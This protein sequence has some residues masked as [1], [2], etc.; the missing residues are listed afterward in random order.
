MEGP[1]LARGVGV[2]RLKRSACSEILES[3]CGERE[4]ARTSIETTLS[5]LTNS[6]RGSFLTAARSASEK[7]AENPLSAERYESSRSPRLSCTMSFSP[8]STSSTES[9][10]TTMYCPGILPSLSARSSRASAEAKAKK[11]SAAHTGRRKSR[12][13]RLRIFMQSSYIASREAQAPA[14][15]TWEQVENRSLD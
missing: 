2:T 13:R 3:S 7:R 6:T 5:S 10:N 4:S 9:L 14:Y 12:D 8:A 11:R 15:L 1:A